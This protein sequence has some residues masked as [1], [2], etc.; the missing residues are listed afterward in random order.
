MATAKCHIATLIAALNA[1]LIDRGVFVVH[2][3]RCFHPHIAAL[4]AAL[5]DCDHH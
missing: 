2:T 5:I 4:I 1:A 3:L